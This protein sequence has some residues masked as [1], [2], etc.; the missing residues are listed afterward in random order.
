[1]KK[2]LIAVAAVVVVLA[3]VGGGYVY[4]VRDSGPEKETAG[5]DPAPCE[6]STVDSIDGTWDVV[7]DDSKGTIVI[8]E[9]IGGVADHEAT[10]TTGPLSGTVEVEGSQV[11]AADITVDMAGLAFTDSPS[12]G[13]ADTRSRAMQSQG[14]ETDEFP[15]ATF[16]LTEPID[17]GDDVTSGDE[18]RSSATGDLTVHGVTKSITFDV[19]VSASGDTFRLTP[20]EFIPIVL[21]DFDMSVSAPGF[22]ADVSDEGSFDFLVVIAQA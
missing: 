6:A 1:M 19:A 14:L 2:T 11:T 9:T 21:E 17:L 13:T 4:F 20:V 12:V 8:T 3:A 22:V 16:S 5:C 18:V 7:G 10:G 15:E